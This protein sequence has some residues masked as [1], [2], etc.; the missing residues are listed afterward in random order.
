[1]WALPSGP[2]SPRWGDPGWVL[3]E[4]RLDDRFPA[5]REWAIAGVRGGIPFRETLPIHARVSPGDDLQAAIDTAANKGGGVVWLGAGEYPLTRSLRLASGV[6]LRGESRDTT[7]ISVRMKAPFF[8][9]SGQPQV[10]AI[11]GD[12][13][14]RAGLEDLTVS[15]DAVDFEPYDHD[16]F[17]APWD[18]RVFHEP[19]PR[20][21]GLWVHLVIFDESEDG[22]VDNCRFLRAGT[23][24]LGLRRSRHF[25]LRDN[26]IERAYIKQDSMH[27]G[28]F[29]IWGTSHSLIIN[30]KVAKIRHF[31]LMLPGC[32]YN[33]VLG[34][35]FET[36]LN[37]HDADDGDNLI[38]G[39]RF[40]TP[41][42]HSWDAVARGAPDKHRP[43]GAGNL[44]FNVTAI[45]KGV[46]GFSRRGPVPDPG[47]VYEVAT[48]F[49][50][51][52]V[53]AREGPPPAGG[54]L[55]A[56]RRAGADER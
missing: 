50:G 52:P 1:M 11:R 2:D 41:V 47:V 16:D 55:Y 9:T 39:A 33:V 20:D 29:G 36:D 45:S 54:T 30:Q 49:E 22:W 56:V 38:E 24:P 27:G 53:R 23:H 15:Y 34:G 7:V 19:E 37:F 46:P 44:L 48:T 40:A 51:L 31:A 12:H 18:R 26:I 13:I 42:W 32:R 25:T 5:M 8:R 17:H 28:Y 6:V 43:P 21:D 35:H 4:T 3:D 10:V 14:S